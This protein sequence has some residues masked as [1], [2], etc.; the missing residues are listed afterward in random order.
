MA[1]RGGGARGGLYLG[2]L[3]WLQLAQAVLSVGS[4]FRDDSGVTEPSP[5]SPTL[6]KHT[7]SPGILDRPTGPGSPAPEELFPRACGKRT[8][9]IVGGM[10]APERKWPWQVILQS[11][12]AHV[13]GGSLI[14]SRWVLTAAHCVSTKSG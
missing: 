9:K 12:G 14:S 3:L 5:E 7:K 4:R 6:T 10:P 13:C 8:M 1:S 2:L 11:N